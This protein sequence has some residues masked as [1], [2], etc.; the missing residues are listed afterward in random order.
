MQRRIY[1]RNVS[2]R[3][4]DLKNLVT[5]CSFLVL[6]ACCW[7]STSA[8]IFLV[9]E[10]A[11]SLEELQRNLQRQETQPVCGEPADKECVH[12]A[13]SFLETWYMIHSPTKRDLNNWSWD[14]N[15]SM[16]F[17]PIHLL[18][19]SLIACL[20]NFMLLG[21]ISLPKNTSTESLLLESVHIFFLTCSKALFVS[22]LLRPYENAECE[23]SLIPDLLA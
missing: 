13:R 18:K 6:L 15:S 3:G 20:C 17:S 14:C 19:A 1:L 9:K 22:C 16:S 10:G 23:T 7:L 5:A 21:L 4:T 12:S 8:L 2:L 11:Q